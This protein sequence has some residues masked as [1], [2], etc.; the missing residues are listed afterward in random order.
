MPHMRN[1]SEAIRNHRGTDRH[2]PLSS[3]E[4][5]PLRLPMSRRNLRR[6]PPVVS[7]QWG[8]CPGLARLHVW[9]GGRPVRRASEASRAPDRR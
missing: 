7:K 6:P 9:P 5:G 4:S 8:G 1:T 2:S 3:G